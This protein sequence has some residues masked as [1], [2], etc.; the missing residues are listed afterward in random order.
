MVST[1]A[2][3]SRT[4]SLVPRQRWAISKPDADRQLELNGTG[5][6]LNNVITA[7]Q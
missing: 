7:T 4:F 2:G 5:N 1:V 3:S 6:A